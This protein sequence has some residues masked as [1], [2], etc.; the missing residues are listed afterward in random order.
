MERIYPMTSQA[1]GFYVGWLA[2]DEF[3]SMYLDNQLYMLS[4]LN[5][6]LFSRFGSDCFMGLLWRIE[7][8]SSDISPTFRKLIRFH[9]KF[10]YAF[11]SILSKVTFGTTRLRLK[12]KKA[13]W[14]QTKEEFKK[15]K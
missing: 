13:F 11:Y 3:A 15:R 6:K 5:Q 2:T 14:K 7:N 1:D 12:Q 10:K 9:S 8:F 4:Q